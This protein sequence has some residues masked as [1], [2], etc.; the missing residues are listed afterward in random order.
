M[1]GMNYHIPV[2]FKD[3]VEWIARVRRSNAT[4]PPTAVRNFVFES[5]YATLKFLEKTQVPTPRVYDFALD[6]QPGNEVGVGY[7]LMEMMPGKCMEWDNAT[8]S[9]QEKFMEKIADI[10]VE[11]RNYP[12]ECIGSLREVPEDGC[13]IGPIACEYVTDIDSAAEIVPLG[14]FHSSRDHETTAARFVLDRIVQREICTAERA[15]D[16]YLA[17][18]YLL[19]L[20]QCITP[21]NEGPQK[22]YLKHADSKSDNFLVDDDFNITAIIDWEWAVT[23]GPEEAFN[24]PDFLIPASHF[25][26]GNI[27]PGP[28]EIRFA[29]ILEEKGHRDIAQYVRH[30]RLFHFLSFCSDYN[31]ARDEE[32]FLLLFK[33]L[34]DAAGVDDGLE[35][36]DWK[37]VALERYKDDEG[38]KD[39]LA[40]YDHNS[41]TDAASKNTSTETNEDLGHGNEASFV[42]RAHMEDKRSK[43]A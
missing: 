30:G 25:F 35:W 37:V 42:S 14:P 41:D 7:I 15:V 36:E 22:F 43:A 6:Q 13:N 4:S 12:F 9:Q 39:L 5:E 29:E 40:K 20:I 18:R 27:T 16:C 1:G 19:D 17:H 28:K 31:F 33:G 32:G 11:L 26:D 3:G 38:L 21:Q 8:E 34:R 23:A 2:I 10:F 24:T